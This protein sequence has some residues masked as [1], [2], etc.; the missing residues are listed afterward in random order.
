M[1]QNA[2]VHDTAAEGS[3]N[4]HRVLYSQATSCA[5]RAGIVQITS[6]TSA[7]DNGQ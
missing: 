1:F 4:Y 7:T 5:E 6:F 3:Y 2:E